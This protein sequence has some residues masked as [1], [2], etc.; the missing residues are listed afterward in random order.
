VPSALRSEKKRGGPPK[1]SSSTLEVRPSCEFL[2]CET[3]SCAALRASTTAQ[4]FAHRRIG[5]CGG[6][7]PNGAPPRRVRAPNSFESARRASGAREFL[8][9]QSGGRSQAPNSAGSSHT[10]VARAQ[11][12]AN[13]RVASARSR[14]WRERARRDVRRS[15]T[16]ARERAAELSGH[17]PQ[18]AG[19]LRARRPDP[20]ESYRNSKG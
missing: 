4:L 9:E 16:S 18:G 20:S 1:S 7:T 11:L 15:H 17:A 8:G 14:I 13:T 12:S 5:E 10:P 6:R 3:T 2:A 19:K